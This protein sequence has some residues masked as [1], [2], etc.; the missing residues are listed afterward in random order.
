MKFMFF[1]SGPPPEGLGFSP[2]NFESSPS[3]QTL[4]FVCV[5]L[6]RPFSYNHFLCIFTKDFLISTLCVCLSRNF[7]Y[8]Q[9]YHLLYHLHYRNA[10]NFHCNMREEQYYTGSIGWYIIGRKKFCFLFICLFLFVYFLMFLSLRQ[11]VFIEV[12]VELL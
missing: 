3:P 7:L 10:A 12:L 9:I 4:A 6:L 1:Y 5:Y 11:R 8:M 2:P